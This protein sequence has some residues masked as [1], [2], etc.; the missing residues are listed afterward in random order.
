MRKSTNFRVPLFV[1]VLS[2]ILASSAVAAAGWV[3]VTTGSSIITNYGG[4]ALGGCWKN[5]NTGT[6]MYCAV[7]DNSITQASAFT[8][9]QVFFQNSN[10][11]QPAQA[12]VTYY[13]GNG[14]VCGP[15]TPPNNCPNHG[16]CNFFVDIT[17]WQT[18]PDQFKFM[19]FTTLTS[20]AQLTGFTMG[21]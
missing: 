3:R 5:T 18:N 10:A 15:A 21:Y 20:G 12:C 1:F 8:T 7:P 19:E 16:V 13:N 14:G 2:A 4:G 11:T 9:A 17:V 6:F